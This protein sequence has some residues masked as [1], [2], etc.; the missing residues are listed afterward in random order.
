MARWG[1][2]LKFLGLLG[3]FCCLSAP[4]R[5]E[6]SEAASSDWQGSANADLSLEGLYWSSGTVGPD[7]RNLRGIGTVKLPASLRYTRAF[8]VRA[9]PILQF[10]PQN[11]STSERYYQDLQ[12][13]YLQWQ[14]LPLT[15]QAGYNVQAWG[16][17][18]VFNPLDVVNARRYHDP[19]RSEKM[20]AATLLAKYQAESFFVEGLY[21]PWQRESKVPG[22]ESRWLPRNI[23][24]S[25]TIEDTVG[26]AVLSLPENITYRYQQSLTMDDALKNNFGARLKFR[27]P[28]FDWTL[29]GFQ[30]AAT[31]PAVNIRSVRVLSTVAYD[32]TTLRLNV[33]PNTP[34]TL[35]AIYYKTRMLGTSFVWVLG[36]FLLKGA[37]AHTH[38]ISTLSGSQLP[39]DSLENALGLERSF[40]VG[41]GTLTGILQGTYVNR[42]ERLDSNS[43]SLA[44]MFDRAAMA[45]LRWAPGERFTATASFLYDL[46]YEG[47]FEHLD[48]G[49]KLA[50]GWNAK[51]GADFMSGRPETPIG[52]Y[53]RNDR[54]TVSLNVQL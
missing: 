33:D 50:D 2:G 25:R 12:E 22:T 7:S 51:L 1:M 21:I 39:K 24:K 34:I 17:T 19:F 3:I 46:R 13:G 32:A 45:G 47:H 10:D 38:V 52:T 16:D 28:G 14:K 43:V 11:P 29:A 23:Y 41:E 26:T 30:G 53:G 49:Y 37:S 6:S 20:G 36:D 18:D 42:Q 15:L 40:P 54:V 4:A 5:A 31:A 9:L 44:R 27:F 48:L 35:R 8:R